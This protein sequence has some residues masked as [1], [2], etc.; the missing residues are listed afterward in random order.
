MDVQITLGLPA[1]DIQP[2]YR[3]PS[4]MPS[5]RV[6]RIND[7][8]LWL[9][10]ALIQC[11]LRALTTDEVVINFLPSGKVAVNGDGCKY[12]TWL[13]AKTNHQEIVSLVEHYLL[14]HDLKISIGYSMEETL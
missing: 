3:G 2:P 11:S 4:L 7:A 1:Q 9:E 14:T 6:N 13:F 5:K 10:Q 12:D 8:K